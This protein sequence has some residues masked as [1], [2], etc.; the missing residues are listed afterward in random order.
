M[1]EVFKKQNYIKNW[2]RRAPVYASTINNSLYLQQLYNSFRWE[3]I[4]SS[5]D[6]GA[7]PMARTVFE[8]AAI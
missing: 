6:T 8:P 1:Y 5:T 7:G 2:S 3:V 4:P